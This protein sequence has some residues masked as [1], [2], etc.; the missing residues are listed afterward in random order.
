MNALY[1]LNACT[2]HDQIIIILAS[3]SIYLHLF[4][5]IAKAIRLVMFAT[6]KHGEEV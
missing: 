6:P 3:A 1:I 2:A 5:L 4:V